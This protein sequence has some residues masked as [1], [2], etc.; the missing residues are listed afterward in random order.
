MLMGRKKQEACKDPEDVEGRGSVNLFSTPRG[1]LTKVCKEPAYREV[2][3]GV[4]QMGMATPFKFISLVMA[5][6]ETPLL[7]PL[8]FALLT[9]DTWDIWLSLG[10]H[11]VPL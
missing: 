11:K 10:K 1:G 9:P 3:E 5:G 6:P 7:Q 8:S 4:V 2:E